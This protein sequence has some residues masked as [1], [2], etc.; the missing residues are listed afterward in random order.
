MNF[1]HKPVLLEETIDLL[2]IKSDGVYVDGT[3]GGG[4]HSER[5]LKY[6]NKGKLISIDQDPDAIFILKERFYYNNFSIIIQENFSNVISVLR[7][8]DIN[9]VDGVLLDIGVSSYQLDTASRGFSFHQDAFLDMRMSKSGVSAYDIINNYK[10]EDLV[11]IIR[12]Y[13]EEKFS[14]SIV[15]SII[16]YREKKKIETTL[17]LAEIIKNSVPASIR[18]VGHPA[19]KT[20]QAIRIVVNKELEVLE[21]GLQEAFS[22]LK[23]GGRLVV[24]TFHSL[25]DR[26]VKKTMLSWCTGCVCPVDFPVC[27]CENKPKARL[28]NKK[29]IIASEN[30]LKNN[31]R[32]RSAKLRGCIKL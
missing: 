22:C 17:E 21:K 28:I 23:P 5:I 24:I 19:R 8:L 26:I 6:I 3:A 16:K 13:G 1:K 2:D 11:F 10:Y 9:F 4:G 18:R 27:I 20:F 7:N 31:Q 30:E 32:S 14:K 25:E 29:P 12:K 15:K